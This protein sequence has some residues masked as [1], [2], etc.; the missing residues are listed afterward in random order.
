MADVFQ[1]RYATAY[2]TFY[3]Q[4]DYAA[5]CEAVVKLIAKFGGGA[6]GAILDLGCGTGRHAVIMA[7]RGFSVTGVDQSGAMVAL[8]LERARH[9]GLGSNPQFLCGDIRTFSSDRRFDAALMNFN[10]LGYMT[11]NDDALSAL[12]ATRGNLRDGGLL[13]ADF[14]YGPAILADPPGQNT[15]TFGADGNGF[16]RA[17]TGHHLPD[18]QC[19]EIH[20]K[21]SKLEQG[22]I[23]DESTEIHRVRYFFPLEL[24]LLL[25]ISGFQLLAL[26]GFPD[27]DTPASSQKWVAAMVAKSI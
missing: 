26:T 23:V 4:K 6:T 11:S 24:E 22:R 18:E 2:D 16:I 27:V 12:G 19:C 10:V 25:R 17:S 8:A 9:E 21:V 20:L 1:D 5:E 13:V 14:W 15:R 3:A 7:Q